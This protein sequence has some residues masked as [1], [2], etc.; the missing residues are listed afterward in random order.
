MAALAATAE[1][2]AAV[3]ARVEA[4]FA[5]MAAQAHAYCGA[6]FELVRTRKQWLVRDVIYGGTFRN[7]VLRIDPVSGQYFP[8]SS[9]SHALGCLLE[10]PDVTSIVDERGRVIRS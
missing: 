1:T 9:G 3:T 10:V 6:V 5:R 7:V 2:E 4:L 8:P